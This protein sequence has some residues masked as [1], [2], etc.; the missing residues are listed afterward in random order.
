MRDDAENNREHGGRHQRL[1]HD[2]DRSEDRL[3]IGGHQIAL[4]QQE[5]QVA[6]TPQ[7]PEIDAKQPVFRVDIGDGI[8]LHCITSMI[9]I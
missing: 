2:P 7:L 6:V 3:L 1:D 4:D 5:D 8:V 9:I